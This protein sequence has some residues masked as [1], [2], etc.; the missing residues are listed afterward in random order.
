[1]TRGRP[2]AGAMSGGIVRT[3]GFANALETPKKN[4]TTNMNIVPV[5]FV[6]A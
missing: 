6:R 5:G 1:M 2:P 3:A 4:A